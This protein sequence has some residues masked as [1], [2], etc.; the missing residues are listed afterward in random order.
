MSSVEWIRQPKL[1]PYQMY[2]ETKKILQ[3]PESVVAQAVMAQAL[4]WH[5]NRWRD[6]Y[7]TPMT[8]LWETK[9]Q[10]TPKTNIEVFL[11]HKEG[12]WI[13]DESFTD[14]FESVRQASRIIQ[15]GDVAAMNKAFSD[16]A[17]ARG[18]VC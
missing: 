7:P 8:V 17:A 16:F 12:D 9:Y 4:A 2:A 5:K 13:E 3:E 1:T 11:Q 18:A 15:H 10:E 14:F 6:H